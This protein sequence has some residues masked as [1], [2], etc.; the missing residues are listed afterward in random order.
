MVK[1]KLDTRLEAQGAEFLVLGQLLIQKVHCYKSYVN[2]PGYD[3]IAIDPLTNKM[4]R[5]QVKSRWRTNY[6]KSF[7]IKNFQ[8]D[9]VVHVA[10]NRGDG[11][12]KRNKKKGREVK[13]PE[14]FIFPTEV[15][16]AVN[17]FKPKLKWGIV[18]LKKID[19]DYI[20][21][22]KDK[23]DLIIEFLKD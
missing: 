3:L 19:P 11:S 13:P 16:R 9:F 4:A 5:L 8:S 6:N 14:F 2:F 21:K 15:V 1:K 23:W 22:Y 18:H 10:L 17:K 7:P 20:D 12:K